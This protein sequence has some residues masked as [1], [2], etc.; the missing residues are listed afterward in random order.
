MHK[1][2]SYATW[3]AAA[4]VIVIAGMAWLSQKGKDAPATTTGTQETRD[5]LPVP[6]KTPEISTS[7]REP[8]LMEGVLKK[9]DNSKKGNYMLVME[10]KTVYISTSRDFSAL[11]GKTVSVTYEGTMEDF[12][13]GSISEKR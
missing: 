7:Q 10:G 11:V 12:K 5:Q 13:L 1:T 2:K 9:S 8:G 6:S 4:V 3:A